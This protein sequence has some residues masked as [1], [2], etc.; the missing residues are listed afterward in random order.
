[1]LAGVLIVDALTVGAMTSLVIV[2]G[3]QFMG[4]VA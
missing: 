4:T 2:V 3:S 1:V